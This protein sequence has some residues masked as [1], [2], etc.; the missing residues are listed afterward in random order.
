MPSH[1]CCQN[2]TVQEYDA[3][4]SLISEMEFQKNTMPGKYELPLISDVTVTLL[5]AEVGIHRRM[6][7]KKAAASVTKQQL[8]Y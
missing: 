6:S 3:R 7:I 4:V 2:P 1:I 8:Q 5:H